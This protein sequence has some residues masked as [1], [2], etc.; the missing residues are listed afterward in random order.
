MTDNE[1]IKALECRVPHDTVCLDALDLI[2]HLKA[3]NEQYKADKEEYIK[4]Y[5][6][7]ENKLKYAEAERKFEHQRIA[8]QQA[9]IE[10]LKE[11]NKKQKLVIEE[12]EDTINPLPFETDFD[13]AI[14]TAKSEAIK[15][16]A[17]RLKEKAT[18]TFYE[19]RKYVDTEDI[20]NLVKEMVG[21]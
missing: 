10:R 15:E 11:E 20:D 16:F 6:E 12:I 1:I 9:E 7:L 21:E 4:D 2:N 14:R 17:E 19:E 18:S 8:Y 13:K 3:E 5:E